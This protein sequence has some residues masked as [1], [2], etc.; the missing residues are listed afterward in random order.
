M[1]T[2]SQ[3]N[4][5]RQAQQ[6]QDALAHWRQRRQLPVDLVSL[7]EDRQGQAVKRAQQHFRGRAG[8]G[9]FGVA[10]V[11]PGH[12]AALPLQLPSGLK[13][14]CRQ[15]PQANH[16]QADQSGDAVIRVQIDRR[17][18]QRFAFEAAKAALDQILSPVG[19]H[20]CGS[21]N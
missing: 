2:Q 21:D 10:G 7:L 12:R 11:D 6:L 1:L 4:I 16:Q 3:V 17:Q 15:H 5:W 19:Q 8:G 18:R 9:S 20:A 14:Q 13:L